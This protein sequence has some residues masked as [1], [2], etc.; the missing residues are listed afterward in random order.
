[1]GKTMTKADISEFLFR[2]LF[3]IIFIGLGGEH[4][5][6]DDLIRLLGYQRGCTALGYWRDG[7]DPM[8]AVHPHRTYHV[9]LGLGPDA[10]KD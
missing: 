10:P 1:M 2:I 9:R 5:F 8:T 7:E 3:C 6:K 4:L